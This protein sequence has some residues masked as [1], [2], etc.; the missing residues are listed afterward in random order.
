[1][2][3]LLLK[4]GVGKFIFPLPLRKWLEQQKAQWQF[5]YLPIG[6]EHLLRTAE[7]EKHHADPFDR[8]LVSQAIV[9]NIGILT[10]DESI[11]RNPVHVIW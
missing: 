2:W 3:E 4:I 11:A 7:I 1:M 9:E 5:N 10:P 6:L 8:L